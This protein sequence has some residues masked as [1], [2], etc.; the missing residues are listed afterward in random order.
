[1][2]ATGVSQRRNQT[3]KKIYARR[4]KKS[5]VGVWEVVSLFLSLRI[6]RKD[7]KKKTFILRFVTNCTTKY[8]RTCMRVCVCVG[9]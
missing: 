6:L 5:K 9:V 2:E 3:R 1:M 4:G 7:I 8:R